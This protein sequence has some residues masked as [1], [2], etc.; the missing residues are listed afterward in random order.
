MLDPE[1][2]TV[3][4]TLGATLHQVEGIARLVRGEIRLDAATGAATGELVVDATSAE[5]GHDGRDRDMHRKVLESED[6]PLIVFRPERLEGDPQLGGAVAA[7]LAGR[8]SIHG[9]E[10][11]LSVEVTGRTEGRRVTATARFTV[12]YVEWGMRDPSKLLL[13]VKK[14]VE[15]VVEAVGVWSDG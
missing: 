10:H 14:E 2:T 8:L 11:P 12:P 15:V 13:R 5:T 1:A 4:F 7:R 6:Y 9:A 3:R